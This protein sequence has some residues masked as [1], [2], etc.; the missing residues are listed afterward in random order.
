M[1]SLFKEQGAWVAQFSDGN[2]QRPRVRL[3]KMCK[4]AAETIRSRIEE[5]ISCRLAGLPLSSETSVWL[6]NLPDDMLV[7]LSKA[8]LI[9]IQ[10][11][12]LGK[13]WE[14][15][16][17]QKKDVKA[18]TL[19]VYDYV[20]HRLFSFFDR[21]INLRKL[22]KE[23]FEQWKM[24]LRSDYCNPR[25]GKP[26]V[27]A[28]V[29]GSITKVKA[30]FN[31]AIKEK[32]IT[33]DQDPLQ[34]VRRG[35]FI[36]RDKDREITMVEYYRLLDASPCQD[37]RVIIA[38]ARI[39]ALRPCEI[40]PL[41]W[42][43]VKWETH[44]LLVKSTKTERYE[45]K[46]SREVPLF[47]ELRVELERLFQDTSSEGKELVINRYRPGQNLGTTFSDIVQKAGLE[48]IPRPFDN[49]RAS[50]STEVYAEHGAFLE[51][52]WIGHSSKIAKNCYL[53]IRE[54][55]IE[56]AAGLGALVQNFAPEAQP[57]ISPVRIPV[58]QASESARTEL[59]E[60]EKSPQFVG[61]VES[62]QVGAT[63]R[64]PKRGH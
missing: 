57:K 38:L 54:S 13:L 27:E 56:R 36:N 52:K 44:R 35:S 48:P 46:E 25:T 49:M 6:G 32:W 12:T 15:F 45:G 10:N 37:W 62:L 11:H 64:L 9:T 63:A 2:G 5:I 51:S 59:Q 33:K 41:R 42:A 39:G 23:H 20:E 18:S 60:K 17:K 53:Q 24:F 50:R 55:D 61:S 3:G 40:L 22:T 19:A 34:G 28:T 30:V 8:K 14:T 1:A 58:R 26:L 47:P 7:K 31:W 43:D 4:K 21:E 29:A 16:R